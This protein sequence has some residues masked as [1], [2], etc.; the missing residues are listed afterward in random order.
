MN[1]MQITS[2]ELLE[3]PRRS[4]TQKVVGSELQ[5]PKISKLNIMGNLAEFASTTDSTS[6]STAVHQVPMTPNYM[7]RTSAYEQHLLDRSFLTERENSVRS[8]KTMVKRYR[9]PDDVKRVF[10][11]SGLFSSPERLTAPKA[12]VERFQPLPDVD[13]LDLFSN[14]PGQA[15]IRPGCHLPNLLES[16]RYKIAESLRYQLNWINS[17][18]NQQRVEG[19]TETRRSLIFLNKARR[20]IAGLN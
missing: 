7:K 8:A 9:R 16:P 5:L 20:N 12:P 14:K 3:V 1:Y 15:K 13:G 11:A 18:Q 2:S 4:R 10:E 17:P 19:V 6:V